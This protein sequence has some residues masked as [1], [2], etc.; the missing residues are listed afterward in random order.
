MLYLDLL[1][2]EIVSGSGISWAIC[3]SAPRP[4]QITT[5][6]PNTQFFTCRMPFL[7][8]NQQL[9][10]QQFGARAGRC[11][12]PVVR[13]YVSVRAGASSASALCAS[14][15]DGS[16]LEW[17]TL[18]RT[19]RPWCRR[20]LSDKQTNNHLTRYLLLLL[21]TVITF[22]HQQMGN[23]WKLVKVERKNWHVDNCGSERCNYCHVVAVLY[24]C[25]L[26]TERPFHSLASLHV[27]GSS[28]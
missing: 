11:V 18:R 24:A 14:W 19:Y 5:L 3:K 8:P 17:G 2:Q 16:S 15:S 28:I 23:G 10:N 7:P 6:A 21:L 25:A 27:R 12:R 1:E 22:I 26:T 13:R 4:R 20:P 9:I